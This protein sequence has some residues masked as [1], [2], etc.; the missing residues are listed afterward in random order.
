VT[1]TNWT[2]GRSRDDFLGDWVLTRRIEDRRAGQAG[3]FEGTARFVADGASGAIY[4]ES[5][6][7]QVGSAAPLKAERRYLYDFAGGMVTIRFAN[8]RDFIQFNPASTHEA[9]HAC[10][11]DTYRASHD[12]SRWPQWHAVWTVSGPRKDY[13]MRTLWQRP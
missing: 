9:V 4:D 13:T 2:Q 5:G 11:P 10:D 1:E 7:L 12:F 8:G 3:L 6:F